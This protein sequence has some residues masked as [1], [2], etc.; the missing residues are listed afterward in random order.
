[1]SHFVWVLMGVRILKLAIKPFFDKEK[2]TCF[3]LFGWFC[4]A[5][6]GDGWFCFLV[7]LVCFFVG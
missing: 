7:G 2:V 3:F 6:L 4:L 5:W 1:M